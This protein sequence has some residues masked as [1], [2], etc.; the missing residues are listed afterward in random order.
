MLQ[1]GEVAV[2]LKPVQE[3]DDRTTIKQ[4]D[5]RQFSI[6]G[7]SASSGPNAFKPEAKFANGSEVRVVGAHTIP[8]GSDEKGEE[9]VGQPGVFQTEDRAPWGFRRS[10]QVNGYVVRGG[11]GGG[12]K[13]RVWKGKTPLRVDKDAVEASK[14]GRV[15][16]VRP[17]KLTVQERDLEK[18][19]SV[20]EIIEGGNLDGVDR[21]IRLI[22]GGSDEVKVSQE[23][24]GTHQ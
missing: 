15:L 23:G 2:F 8:V 11:T 22:T 16:H 12:R 24:D 21:A 4:V 7:P 13:R 1:G 10:F 17:S 14:D 9:G 18:A 6:S 20:N 3:G 19:E 5:R